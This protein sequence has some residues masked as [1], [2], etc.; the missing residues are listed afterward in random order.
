MKASDLIMLG[1]FYTIIG[2]VSGQSGTDMRNL[3]TYLFTTSGYNNNIRPVVNQSVPTQVSVDLL[4]TGLL[5]IDEA[6]QQMGSVGTLIIKWRDEFLSWTPSSYGE[7]MYFDLPQDLIWKPD[8]Q[9]FNGLT[10]FTNL[11]GSF[12]TVRVFSTGD[13]IWMPYKVFQTK[14]RIDVT[15]FPFDRQKCQITMVA[16]NSDAS[17]VSLTIGTNGMQIDEDIN[18]GQWTLSSPKADVR[19]D[20]NQSLITFELMLKRKPKVFVLNIMIPM[21]FL[22]VLDVF[23][24]IIPNDSGEKISYSVAVMLALSIFMTVVT[25]ILPPTSYSTSYLEM[26]I[27]LILALG[28]LILIITAISLRIHERGQDREIPFWLQKLTVLSWKLNCRSRNNSVRFIY[29]NKMDSISNNE[30][31]MDVKNT[32]DTMN[33]NNKQNES[34]FW[35]DVT[36]AVDFFMFWIF[37]FIILI[38][39]ASLLG[40]AASS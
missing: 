40:L 28:T 27:I 5:G 13:V 20:D 14:C 3:Y 26:Y 25:S 22:I 21:F 10:D 15:Y 35:T 9:V 17:S 30:V 6:K 34:V 12:M 37:S 38:A 8:L 29:P 7:A 31:E 1:I 23:T 11:G 2:R 33:I 24:F 18:D 16:W 4:L 36:S 19:V 32:K 39:S